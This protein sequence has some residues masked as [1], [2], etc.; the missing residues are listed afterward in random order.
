MEGKSPD[1]LTNVFIR[2]KQNAEH[3]IQS[4]PLYFV[5]MIP[6][7]FKTSKQN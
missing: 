3:R 5:F 1:S 7:S 2:A 4:I 6:P